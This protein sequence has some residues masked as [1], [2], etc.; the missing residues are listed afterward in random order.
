MNN[1]IG[2]SSPIPGNYERKGLFSAFL[3]SIKI[4][5][6]SFLVFVEKC[7]KKCTIQEQDIFEVRNINF[8]PVSSEQSVQ[9]DSEKA[10]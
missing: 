3:G 6:Y 10:N 5:N 9:E 4:F 2:K 1:N 7:E 8:M